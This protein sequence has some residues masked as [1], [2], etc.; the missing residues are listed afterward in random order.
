MSEF[1]KMYKRIIREYPSAVGDAADEAKEFFFSL[2]ILTLP[3]T[4]IVAYP[5]YTVWK[6]VRP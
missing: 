2:V 4:F 1:L 3:V 5:I 6:K